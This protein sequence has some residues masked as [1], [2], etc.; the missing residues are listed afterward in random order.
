MTAPR[1]PIDDELKELGPDIANVLRRCEERSHVVSL[2]AVAASR[3]AKAQSSAGA[4]LSPEKRLARLK[5]AGVPDRKARLVVGLGHRAFD[6]RLEAVSYADDF[7]TQARDHGTHNVCVLSSSVHGTGKTAA[8]AFLLDA[9][10][11][12]AGDGVARWFVHSGDLLEM[13]RIEHEDDRVRLKQCRA[14]VIDELGTE[15]LDGK[16]YWLSFVKWLVNARIEGAGLTVITTNLDAQEFRQRYGELV[17]DRLREAARWFDLET[18][19]S[20]RGA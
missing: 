13:S 4:S 3:A 10:E 8:A 11:V 19:T 12:P 2:A 5:S 20:M 17:Y 15:Y 18:D 16:G 7:L 9:Y 6:T 14:L 1:K